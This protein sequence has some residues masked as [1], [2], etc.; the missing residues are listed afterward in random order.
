VKP[1]LQ[2]DSRKIFKTFNVGYNVRVRTYLKQFPSGTVKMLHACSVG[3]F[4]IL[5]KLNYSTYIID[6]SR[7]YGISCTFNVNDL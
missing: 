1:T 4:K 5:N 3:P 6:L 2:T 7:Y